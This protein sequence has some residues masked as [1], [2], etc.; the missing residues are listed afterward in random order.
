MRRHI[1]LGQAAIIKMKQVDHIMS[2]KQSLCINGFCCGMFGSLEWW[3]GVTRNLPFHLSERSSM[4][5]LQSSLMFQSTPN[6]MD[7]FKGFLFLTSLVSCRFSLKPIHWWIQFVN[8][9]LHGP[10]SPKSKDFGQAAASLHREHVRLVPRP[11]LYLHGLGIHRG[12][13]ILHAP[14]KGHWEAMDG[15]CHG[16]HG[17][18]LRNFHDSSASVRRNVHY[19][20]WFWNVADCRWMISGCL[21]IC[22][23]MSSLLPFSS[24]A[25]PRKM[26]TDMY[27]LTFTDMW[28]SLGFIGFQN[29]EGTPRLLVSPLTTTF[30][31]NLDDLGVHLEPRPSRESPESLNWQGWPFRKR[32]IPLL[33]RANHMQLV[34]QSYSFIMFYSFWI[35]DSAVSLAMFGLFRPDRSP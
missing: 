9:R 31:Y 14:A 16:K 30:S 32:T 10:W 15:W 23:F 12:G 26:F 27:D 20:M 25:W 8:Q 3:S 6:S 5:P 33:R 17:K 13:R 34:L 22:V 29:M 21:L 4:L 18:P 2:E 7:W 35:W 24:A 28:V 11:A 1:I 19:N